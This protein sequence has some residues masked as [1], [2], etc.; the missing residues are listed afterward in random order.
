M[1]SLMWMSRYVRGIVDFRIH[2]FTLPVPLNP[3]KRVTV[4]STLVLIVGQSKS[5]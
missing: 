5:Y 2:S 3:Y 1:S 4:R